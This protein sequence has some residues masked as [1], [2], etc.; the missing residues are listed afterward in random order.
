MS[1]YRQA[2]G[3]QDNRK[4]SLRVQYHPALG[5][6]GTDEILRPTFMTVGDQGR[7]YRLVKERFGKKESD[8]GWTDGVVSVGGEGILEDHDLPQSQLPSFQG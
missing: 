4:H 6:G 5:S 1:S 3:S 7:C 2:S 8:Q